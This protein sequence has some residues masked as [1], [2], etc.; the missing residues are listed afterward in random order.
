VN[1]SFSLEFPLPEIHLSVIFA[2]ANP[3]TKVVRISKQPSPVLIMIDK[4]TGEYGILILFVQHK[5]R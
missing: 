3:T 5:D 4:K 1:N 2:A